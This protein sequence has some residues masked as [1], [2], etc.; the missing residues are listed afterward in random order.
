MNLNAFADA[1][2]DFL[3][4]MDRVVQWLTYLFDENKE[5]DSWPPV[6]YPEID[7]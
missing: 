2:N 3:K 1:W 7:A 6:D 5:N 4:F